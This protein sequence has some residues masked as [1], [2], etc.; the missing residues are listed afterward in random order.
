MSAI[1][2]RAGFAASIALRR[3]FQCLVQVTNR[4]NMKCSFCDFWPNGV[5]SSQELTVDDY[6]RVATGMARVGRFLVS[7]E[8][9]EPFVRRDLIDIVRVFA[10]RHVPLLYTNGWYVDAAAARDLFGA[11]LTQVGVSIDFPDARHDAKRVLPGAFR[12]AIDAVKLLRDAAP[13]GGKQVHVMTVLMRENQDCLEPL[14]ELSAGLGVGHCVT[15][16]SDKG[17]RRGHVLDRLPDAGAGEK[18]AGLWKRHRHLRVFEEYLQGIDPFLA[19][20]AM[21]RCR[22]GEQSFNIDH[23]GNVAPCIEKIDKPVGNVR[24]TSIADLVQR[25]RELESVAHCQDCWTLCRGFGQALG[26][27]GSAGAWRDLALRMGSH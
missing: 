10:E 25:M 18:L 9:G 7:I 17:F 20:G 5:P 8:G 22:A 6:R 2:N 1:A 23:V 15:L 3:P 26:E 19:K 14:L 21:P 27:G 12:R 13:R 11:G 24:D 4:C 16:L